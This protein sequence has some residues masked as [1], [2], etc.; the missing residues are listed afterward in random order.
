MEQNQN[1]TATSTII[2]LLTRVNFIKIKV[3][4]PQQDM[5]GMERKKELWGHKFKIV[6]NGLDEAE[7]YSF[8]DS[9]TNQYGNLAKQLEHLDSLVSRL[10]Y[11][12]S[13]LATKLEH[14]D[15]PANHHTE[16]HAAE[17]DEGMERLDL[18]RTLSNGDTIEVDSDK[19]KN[20]HAL[21]RFAERAII[22]ATKQANT[23]K[24]EIEEKAK[25]K[26]I[27]IVAS[28]EE[29]ARVE[30][31]AIIAETEM[32]AKERG[33][34]IIAAAQQEAQE[35]MEDAQQRVEAVEAPAQDDAEQKAQDIV[36]EA[37]KR[38]EEGAQLV[39]QEADQLLAEGKQITEGEI[40]EA[41]D[42]IQRNLLSIVEVFEEPPAKS[43]KKGGAVPE[44]CKTE[45]A[46]NG[47]TETTTDE[48]EEKRDP[49][50]FTGTVELALPPPV[51]LD[52]M[53]QLHKHL[54]R[55]PNVDV[56]NLGGSVDKGITIRVLVQN[57]TPLLK[58]I[59]KLSEVEEASE[60]LPDADKA[61][62]GRK[63]GEETPIRRI[64][65]TT[66]E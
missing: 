10:S 22:E 61:V 53:L 40:K 27:S 8:V 28:A 42:N 49:D 64:I 18:L 4:Q 52:R 15:S 31:D 13:H 14:L 50:L 47:P 66:K 37:K 59:A 54:K 39:K 20:L 62:P 48:T 21:T 35:L 1:T 36:R 55:T 17:V 65:V 30:A 5:N 11:Q 32:R 41:F 45:A 16:R 63:T 7:V 19:L 43:T 6:K 3:A 26:A 58:V 25:A 24:T 2:S 51:V 12:Y 60:E 33:E 23:T 9:L 44:R 29:R 34:E 46:G 56:L 57:P 38:A